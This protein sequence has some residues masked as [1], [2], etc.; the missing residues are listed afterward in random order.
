MNPSPI[1]VAAEIVLRLLVPGIEPIPLIAR[2]YYTSDDP[3]AVRMSFHVETEEPVEWMFSRELLEAGI[4]RVAGIGDV[5]FWP[6]VYVDYESRVNQFLNI[7]LSSPFGFAHFEASLLEVKAY[8]ARVN[9]R[10]PAARQAAY[11]NWERELAKLFMLGP[12]ALVKPVVVSTSSAFV[13]PVSPSHCAALSVPRLNFGRGIA[14]F[15]A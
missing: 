6:S 15:S 1:I 10:V 3:Y 12:E 5:K 9:A 7:E 11:C 13:T 4:E 14:H 8:L 2:L